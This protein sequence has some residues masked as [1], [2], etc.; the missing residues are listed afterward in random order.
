MKTNF[1]NL[2]ALYSKVLSAIM[3]NAKE[4]TKEELEA[5]KE[6]DEWGE[7]AKGMDPLGETEVDTGTLKPG[8][9]PVEEALS[10]VRFPPDAPAAAVA[11]TTE[12]PVAPTPIPAEEKPR[13]KG[14]VEPMRVDSDHPLYA[15]MAEMVDKIFA[16]QEILERDVIPQYTELANKYSGMLKLVRLG[17][18]PLAEAIRVGEDKYGKLYGGVTSK[19]GEALSAVDQ[20][21][22]AA[23]KKAVAAG[24]EIDKQAKISMKTRPAQ[25]ILIQ[26]FTHGQV[27]TNAII[28]ALHADKGEGLDDGIKKMLLELG[29]AQGQIVDSI[30]KELNPII[31]HLVNTT[32]S[33]DAAHDKMMGTLSKLGMSLSRLYGKV[34][35]LKGPVLGELAARAAAIAMA[36]KG[37]A[38]TKNA[39]EAVVADVSEQL[40]AKQEELLSKWRGL[41]R[42]AIMSRILRRLAAAPEQTENM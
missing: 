14:K 3:R 22:V 39:T 7:A 20:A 25:R 1:R 6:Q 21:L 41:G 19:M 40:R 9:D 27:F 15:K 18:N 32:E 10:G 37:V 29:E 2:K 17:L 36:I 16:E 8:P 11:P 35:K 24:A 4:K 33:F 31:F 12:A 26:K 34:V 28:E 13:G 30:S 23:E 5:E 42:G 38:D